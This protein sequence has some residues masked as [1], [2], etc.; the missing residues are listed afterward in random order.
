MK[1]RLKI[2]YLGDGA[3]IHTKRWVGWFAQRHDVRLLSSPPLNGKK[4]DRQDIQL[5]DGSTDHIIAKINLFRVWWH[6][7]RELKK[8]RPDIVHVHF[9]TVN[10]WLVACSGFR[11][12]VTTAWGSD[13]FFTAGWIK[14]LNIMAMKH[15]AMNTG[16]SEEMIRT[17][18]SS[19]IPSNRVHQIQ[20]GV[21]TTSFVPG[22]NGATLKATLGIPLQAPVLVSPRGLSPIYNIPSIIQ[23]FIDVAQQHPQAHLVVMAFNAD[24]AEKLRATD[25]AE[26]SHCSERIHFVPGLAHDQMPSLFQMATATISVP[27]SDATP[28][29]V[30][31]AMAAGSMIIA[32]DLPSLRQWI[33]PQHNGWLVPVNNHGALTQVM[34]EALTQSQVQRQVWQ[35]ENRAMVMERAS[36]DVQMKMMEDIYY[37]IIG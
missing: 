37:R 8:F 15:A 13:L 25:L 35:N 7:H 4:W 2:L 18:Q 20:F 30:L 29:S 28:V 27:T 26:S 3:S 16:D 12:F 23:A 5:V 17:F 10:S 1:Q 9:E 11:P 24:P 32:S 33:T 34:A 31:E 6:L 14:R 22:P 19:G 21:D 36:Q